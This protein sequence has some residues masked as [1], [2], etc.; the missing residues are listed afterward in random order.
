M[1]T[2]FVVLL[3]VGLAFAG[4]S[5]TNI[6]P[7]GSGGPDG[8]GYYWFDQAEHPDFFGDWWVDISSTGTEI[9]LADD[10]HDLAGSLSFDFNF[11][12]TSYTD[13]YVGSSGTVYFEDNYLGYGNT[14]IPDTNTYGV[15][16]FMAPWWVDLNPT[17]GGSIYFEE[18]TDYFVV[19]FDDVHPYGGTE[20][21]TFVVI[22]W[23]GAPGEHSNIAFLYNSA[24]TDDATIG[25]QGDI[26]TGTESQYD[27]CTVAAGDWYFYTTDDTFFDDYA[28]E[29]ATWGQIKA[30]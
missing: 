7:P 4:T 26:S 20:G 10:D 15:F 14:H 2:T 24:N 11:Y 23:E 1:R 27:P 3:M 18:F 9:V 19:M 30:M 21:I 16:T 28:I 25:I 12:G 8:G 5:L 22:G 13:I 6:A 17:S 29:E